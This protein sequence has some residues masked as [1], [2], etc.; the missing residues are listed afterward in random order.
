MFISQPNVNNSLKSIKVYYL[1]L[2]GTTAIFNPFINLFFSR[3]GLNG[4]EIGAVNGLAAIV[5]M[6][7]APV[8]TRH[9]QNSGRPRT[10]LQ[11]TTLISGAF[12]LVLGYQNTFV[13]ILVFM[14]LRSIFFSGT[15]PMS[16][17]MVVQVTGSGKAGFGSVRLFT[18][19]GWAVV[20]V[21]G[22][23]LMGSWGM[24]VVFWGNVALSLAAVLVLFGVLEQNEPPVERPDQ[25]REDQVSLA[26]VVNY[27]YKNPVMV[28]IGI[29]LAL[30]NFCSSGVNQ[31][32]NIFVAR[33]GGTELDIGVVNMVG[34]LIEVPSMLWADRLV[35]KL[36]GNRV[37]MDGLILYGILR[38]AVFVFP[39]IWMIIITRAFGGISLSFYLVGLIRA[40]S[41]QINHKELSTALAVFMITLPGLINFFATPSAGYLFDLFGGKWLY[42]IASAGCVL[43]VIVLKMTGAPLKN[44]PS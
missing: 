25:V 12:A 30:Q 17:A 29:T 5:S 7:M 31:F 19:L 6:L 44:E 3:Q 33:L 38:G 23:W 34:A 9:S 14:T 43:G 40:I 13:W 37:L 21:A 39:A 26:R 24:G 32:E 27:L 20:V 36:G 11:V 2:G 18:S 35:R 22:G 8:W 10:I 1:I 16:D 4:L 41:E 28:G 42:L 15:A